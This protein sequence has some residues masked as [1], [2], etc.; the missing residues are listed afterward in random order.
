MNPKGKESSTFWGWSKEKRG[1]TQCRELSLCAGSG[2]G[3]QWQALP[4]PMQCEE[5][6]IRTQDLPVTGS[7]TLPLAPGPPFCSPIKNKKKRLCEQ[8]AW[9]I[10]DTNMRSGQTETKLHMREHE[11][12]VMN[13]NMRKE[14]WPELQLG[15]PLFLSTQCSFLGFISCWESWDHEWAELTHTWCA[16]VV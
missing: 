15:H 13:I 4:L 1:C 16:L 2:E 3:C 9:T 5:P 12:C 11:E 14:R 10:C 7:K 8:I 6:A